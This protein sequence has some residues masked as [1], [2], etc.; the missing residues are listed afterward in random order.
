MTVTCSYAVGAGDRSLE[1]KLLTKNILTESK[2]FEMEL[3]RIF[4]L[5]PTASGEFEFGGRGFESW[6]RQIFLFLRYE[7]EITN[8]IL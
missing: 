3:G 4:F 1:K 6:D 2:I 5:P 7:L 8:I